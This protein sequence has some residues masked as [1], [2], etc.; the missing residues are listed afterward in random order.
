MTKKNT[1]AQEVLDTLEA[2]PAAVSQAQ[3]IKEH[4]EY[5]RRQ[6]LSIALE[7]HKTNGGMLTVDQLLANA[8]KFHAYITGEDK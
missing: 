6:A 1:L 5:T 8:V 7:H 3:E 2:T 4:I